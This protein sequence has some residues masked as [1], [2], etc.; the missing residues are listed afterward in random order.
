MIFKTDSILENFQL[1]KNIRLLLEDYLEDSNLT[2]IPS[3]SEL[4]SKNMYNEWMELASLMAD[5]ADWGESDWTNFVVCM[6]M[7]EAT[8][9]TLSSI[10]YALTGLGAV[11]KNTPDYKIENNTLKIEIE[12]LRNVTQI[13]CMKELL[14]RCLEYLVFSK[15]SDVTIE[16]ELLELTAETELDSGFSAEVN[17]SSYNELPALYSNIDINSIDI[18]PIGIAKAGSFYLVHADTTSEYDGSY[19]VYSF[20]ILPEELKDF[21]SSYYSVKCSYE[22]PSGL[23]ES[24]VP[25]VTFDLSEYKLLVVKGFKLPSDTIIKVFVYLNCTLLTQKQIEGTSKEIRI[26]WDK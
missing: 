14:Q 26:A 15:N 11:I 7:A 18:V 5:T 22:F 10:N 3:I 24:E 16:I 17:L 12:I 8:K 20:E 1:F 23:P 2:D 13:D 9:S 21:D 4:Y 19:D 25:Y 6:S